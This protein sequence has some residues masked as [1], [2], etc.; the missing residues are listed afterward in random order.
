MAKVILNEEEICKE[1]VDT[2]IGVESMALKYHV[3]KKRIRDILNRHNIEIKRP[4]GQTLKECFIVSDPKKK[5]YVNGDDYHYIVKDKYGEWVSKDIDNRG[6]FLTSFIREK[7][8]IEIPSLY[9]RDKYYKK[10]GDYWWEQFLT[11]EKV[12]NAD[13]KSCPYCDWETID[14]ENKS[15]AFE[16]HL[17][18]A[19]NI[20]KIEHLKSY[21]SDRDYF[22]AVATIIDVQMECDSSKFVTCKV[23]G[24]KMKKISNAHL[25]LHD[26]TKDEYIIK[27]GKDDIMCDETYVKYK[28]IAHKANLTIGEM[29]G[30]RFTSKAEVEIS[31]YLTDKGLFNKKDRSILDGQELDIYIPSKQ[32]AIEYNGN[33]WHTEYFGGKDRNYHINKLNNCNQKGVKLIQIF[34]DEYLSNKELILNKIGYILGLNYDK[35]KVYARQCEVRTIYKYEAEEFLNKYHVQGFAR[36]TIYY[37]AFYKENLVGVMCFKDGNIKNKCWDIVRFATNYNYRCIALGSKMFSAF[38]KDTKATEVI[39]FAD[40]RWTTDIYDNLYTKMGFVVDSVG[41]PDYKYYL[42][43]NG[44][45]RRIH[46]MSLSK[47]T[48]QTKYELDSRM[49]ESEMAKELGYDRIWDCGLVK[50]VWRK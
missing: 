42:M 25:K 21:P 13:T 22:R 15:G 35:E 3:G 4:G 45:N 32:V 5:K 27:Y 19:H 49:T 34:E 9:D 18:K 39:S 6:G 40:R 10:T 38:L 14:V 46:K 11:Y 12:K 37:G 20:T 28:N 24:K 30:D 16:Q 44:T 2:T 23:C 33:V 26:I 48:M 7:Y 50:Y 29:G 17:L 1:Y 31:N 8:A 43:K 36:A 41:R 47:K